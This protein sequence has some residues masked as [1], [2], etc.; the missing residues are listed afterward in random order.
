MIV[1]AGIMS[2]EIGRIRMTITMVHA[3]GKPSKIRFAAKTPSFCGRLDGQRHGVAKAKH[4]M[5]FGMKSSLVSSFVHFF[6]DAAQLARM[7]TRLTLP[8][9]LPASLKIGW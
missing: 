3:S 6:Y 1:L 4:F 2:E 7:A 8:R 9:A 5:I